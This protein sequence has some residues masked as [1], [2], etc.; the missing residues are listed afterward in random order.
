MHR[1]QTSL[2]GRGTAGLVSAAAGRWLGPGPGECE[3]DLL[4]LLCQ[5]RIVQHLHTL[6]QWHRV[7][8]LPNNRGGVTP[9]PP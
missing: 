1:R 8:N 2:P 9:E 3:C 6:R 4:H 5:L 7:T